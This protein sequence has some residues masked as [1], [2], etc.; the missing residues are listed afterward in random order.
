MR[1]LLLLFS[2]I[3]NLSTGVPDPT[4]T[5]TVTGKTT[6]VTIREKTSNARI[7][8]MIYG[9]MLED[10]NDAVIYGGVVDEKGNENPKW[11]PGGPPTV[12]RTHT[13]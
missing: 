10:C 6:T 3:L 12:T 9:Q 7:D 8:P 4:Y 13:T 5:Q 11:E 1:H 2:S